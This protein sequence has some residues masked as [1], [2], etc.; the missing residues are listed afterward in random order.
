MNGGAGILAAVAL[1]VGVALWLHRS[2]V[3]DERKRLDAH[4]TAR[5]AEIGIDW[6]RTADW[7]DYEG[8]RTP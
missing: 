3:R 4:D 6:T 1:V 2:E 8:R 7:R 5:F